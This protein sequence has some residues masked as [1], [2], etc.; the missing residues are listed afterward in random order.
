MN[1]IQGKIN[2]NLWNF[3]FCDRIKNTA[4]LGQ[5][6]IGSLQ[7]EYKALSWVAIADEMEPIYTG[8]FPEDFLWQIKSGEIGY[9]FLNFLFK[10]KFLLFFLHHENLRESSN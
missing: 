8:N 10:S 4:S 6:R 1:S 3:R 7:E 5:N 2:A 9:H